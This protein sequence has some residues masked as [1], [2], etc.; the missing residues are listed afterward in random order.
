VSDE[1]AGQSRTPSFNTRKH[2][3]GRRRPS[4]AWSPRS[5]NDARGSPSSVAELRCRQRARPHPAD[6]AKS[7]AWAERYGVQNAPAFQCDQV[8]TARDQAFAVRAIQERF[9]LD[10]PPNFPP[11][12]VHLPGQS[13]SNHNHLLGK[14]DGVAASRPDISE[15]SGLQSG[16]LPLPRGG[17]YLSPWSWAAA[18]AARAAT[19]ACAE[20][21]TRRSSRLARSAHGAN[22]R[23]EGRAHGQ[24]SER[25]VME[26]GRG[27]PEPMV[28]TKSDPGPSQWR[29]QA[30]PKLA[31]RIEVTG[32]Q[33]RGEAP[34]RGF[35]WPAPPSATR[36][37]IG[38]PAN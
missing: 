18:A 19:R 12:V 8:T 25:L 5:E 11:S 27:K 38:C 9:P 34:A 20:L 22:G 13:I 15:P 28:V 10:S 36:D 2:P 1:A 6:D 30:G 37:S 23:R 16:D 7:Q 21:I 17:R 26:K 31:N 24:N 3:R 32:S 35:A 14:V 29:G 4:R 33:R